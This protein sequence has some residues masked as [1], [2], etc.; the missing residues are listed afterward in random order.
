MTKLEEYEAIPL[1]PLAVRDKTT[2]ATLKVDENLAL[3][4]IRNTNARKNSSG[5]EGYYG[6]LPLGAGRS[7][8]LIIL[9]LSCKIPETEPATPTPPPPKRRRW[10]SSLGRKDLNT[11]MSKLST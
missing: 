5:G 9:D 2:T 6:R 8:R 1:L 10:G 7:A 4:L 3:E 11:S